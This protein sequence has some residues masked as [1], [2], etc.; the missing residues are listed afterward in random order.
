MYSAVLARQFDAA[1]SVQAISGIGLT[2]NANAA[3]QWQMGALA[4]PPYFQRTLQQRSEPLWDFDKRFDLVLVSLGGNDYNHQNGHVPTNASFSKAFEHF[5][6]F[7]LTHTGNTSKLVAVCG[8][9][10]PLDV[11]RD[12]DNNRCRPCPHVQEAVE[13]MAWHRPEVAHRLSYIFIPCNG[14]VVTGEGD[15][16]RFCV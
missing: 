8:M 9:G 7:V 13:T 6:D 15:I 10:S 2:Q 14:T 5:A 12:P 4:M 16:G 1:L 3:E 11:Q